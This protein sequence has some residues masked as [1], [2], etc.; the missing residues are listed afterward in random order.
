[1]DDKNNLT[2]FTYYYDCA[3][4]YG[5]T[6][7]VRNLVFEGSSEDALKTAMEDAKKHQYSSDCKVAL[8]QKFYMN[9]KLHEPF[10]SLMTF[11]L[12]TKK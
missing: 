1:M 6:Q 3:K 12:S 5:Y 7:G 8:L 4:W 10:P 11:P 2:V 9:I